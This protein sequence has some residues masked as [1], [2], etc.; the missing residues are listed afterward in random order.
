MKK[1]LLFDIDGTL[2]KAGGAGLRGMARACKEVFKIE[3]LWSGLRVDGRADSSLLREVVRHHLGREISEAEKTLFV[4]NYMSQL[5]TELAIASGFEVLPGVQ[6][7]IEHLISR[8]DVVLGL[9]TGN[10]EEAAYLKLRRAGLD[11]YFQFGGF[12]SD[13]EDRPTLVKHAI[14]RANGRLKSGISPKRTFVIGDTEHDITAGKANGVKTLA[15]FTGWTPRERIEAVSPD[16]A[17]ES[18]ADLDA[19]LEIIES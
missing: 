16:H 19:F 10:Y 18:F 1:L 2:L 11:S 3:E 9:Q 8:K 7:L 6:N 14:D 17:L 15:V 12:G 4:K 5:E 13:S